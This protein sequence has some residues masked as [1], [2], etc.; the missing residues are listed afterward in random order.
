[1]PKGVPNT[2]TR[3]PPTPPIGAI[4]T[5]R[6]LTVMLHERDYAALAELAGEQ[7]RTVELQAAWLLAKVLAEAGRTS[8]TVEV[9]DRQ[10]GRAVDHA[11]R[12]LA[13]A[14]EVNGAAA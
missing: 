7:Y 14:R 6:R 10:V 13:R 2:N 12:I 11:E 9:V 5:D 8:T 3:T 1:M 4:P